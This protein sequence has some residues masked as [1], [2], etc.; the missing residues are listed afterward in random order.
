M[1]WVSINNQDRSNFVKFILKST[2]RADAVN[3]GS[4]KIDFSFHRAK[5]SLSEYWPLKVGFLCADVINPV[6]CFSTSMSRNGREKYSLLR[7]T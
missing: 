5:K 2:A 7:E 1:V 3:H 6:L 4:H